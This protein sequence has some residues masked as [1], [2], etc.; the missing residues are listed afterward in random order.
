MI[1][2]TAV[3]QVK[4]GTENDFETALRAAY[5]MI[6]RM[7][8]YLNHELYKCIES[9]HEYIL[10]IRWST[11]KD[12]SMG[13]RKPPEYVHWMEVLQTFMDS[14][15]V[16]KHYVDIVVSGRNEAVNSTQE[17]SLSE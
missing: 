5:E 13:F 10:I 8:G 11:V 17:V 7:R 6:S 15:P 12:H 9:P 4:P 1:L 2:E 16:E 3:M 14:P